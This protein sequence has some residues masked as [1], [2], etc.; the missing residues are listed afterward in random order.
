[1]KLY[2]S[3]VLITVFIFTNL[4]SFMYKFKIFLISYEQFKPLS[5]MTPK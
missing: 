2:N 3:L 1:M 4:I 5:F